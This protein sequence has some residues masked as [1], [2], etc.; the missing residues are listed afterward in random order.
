MNPSLQTVEPANEAVDEEDEKTFSPPPDHH[1][2]GGERA[3]AEDRDSS[4]EPPAKKFRVSE[5]LDVRFLISSK[6]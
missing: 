3:E 6:V 4:L 1:H 5:E 2:N